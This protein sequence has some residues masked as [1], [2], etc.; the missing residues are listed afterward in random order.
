[1]TFGK[2]N[3]IKKHCKS[4]L[5]L[6]SFFIT[7]PVFAVDANSVGAN[8][9]NLPKLLQMFSEKKKSEVDFKEEKYAFYLDA[10]IESSGYLQ[11]SAPNKLNKVILKPEVVSQKINGDTLT[12]DDGNKTHVVDLNEHPELSII[13]RSIINVLS[14]NLAAIKNDFKVTFENKAS[15]WTLT[16]QPHDSFTSSQ[17]ESIQMF[18]NKNLLT[19]MIVKEP[20][21]DYTTTHIYNHR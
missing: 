12:I 15:A 14:G 11:F 5:L 9:L 3:Q 13:L 19:K 7:L 18:G 8:N 21:D 20:N 1:M 16:L 17:V 4:Y 10:P 2:M 6:L